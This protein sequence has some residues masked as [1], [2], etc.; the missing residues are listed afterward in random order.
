[1]ET[2]YRRCYVCERTISVNKACDEN[3]ETYF[4][5]KMDTSVIF[6]CYKCDACFRKFLDLF[7]INFDITY[8]DFDI[9]IKYN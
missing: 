3:D 1:M 7:N 8:C 9:K 6:I 5:H 2:M 4:L